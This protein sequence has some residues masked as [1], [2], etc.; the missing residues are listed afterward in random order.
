MQL[1]AK[2]LVWLTTDHS[3]DRNRITLRGPA[4]MGIWNRLSAEDEGCTGERCATQMGGVCP[5][6]QAKRRAEAAHLLIVNHA[7]LLSDAASEGRV[8]PEY[9]YL[10]IDEAHHLEDA[11][12]SSMSFRTDPQSIERQLADLG[13]QTSGLLGELLR[14]TRAALPEGYFHSVRDYV[15]M[16]VAAAS[17]MT[18]HVNAFFDVLQRFV[19]N[20][21]QLAGSEYTQSVRILDPLRR[22]PEWSE[23]EVHWDNLSH[24]TGGVAEAMAKLA[25][26]LADLQEYDIEDF[27]DLLAGTRAAARHLT[28]L[29]ERLGELVSQ[30]DSNMVYWVDLTPDGGRISA[31]TAPLDIGP[32]VQKHIWYSKEA[33]VLTSATMRTDG[34]FDFIRAQLDAD[35]AEEVVIGSPFDYE[36]STLLYVAND[37]PEPADKARYQ[38]AVEQGIL[39]LCLATQGR[40]LILFTSYAQLRQTTSAISDQLLQ[41]GI[42]VYDQS[43][44]TSRSSL[45]EGFIETD[46]AVLMGTRS[47]WEGVDVPGS[48]LSVLVIVR[49]PFS[50]PSDP[51]FAARSELFEDSFNQYALPETILRFRQGFGRLIRR[52]TDRGVV[53]IFDRRVISKGYGRMFI[54]SLPRCTLRRGRLADL[55][56][57]AAEWLE[58]DV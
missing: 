41:A 45:L 24:F 42:T 18:H 55:P 35:E 52:K 53:A 6:Y 16:V 9:K 44:G 19:R 48:D 40:A 5:F 32:L 37:I 10:I 26:G 50:V 22:Q 15:D 56:R 8:L 47:F 2:L 34:S 30:P 23:V 1:L 7:L 46:K 17:A 57:A 51:L 49:L 25:D 14:E 3:G 31:H 28:E 58:S 12:T 11:V 20:H 27:D 4:E 21:V 38:Q 13:T 29:H 39:D 33:V 54:D 36:K 43:E